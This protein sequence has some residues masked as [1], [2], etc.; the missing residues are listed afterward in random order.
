MQ[1]VIDN[2]F[3]EIGPRTPIKKEC[4]N[5]TL[6]LFQKKF[7]FWKQCNTGGLYTRVCLHEFQKWQANWKTYKLYHLPVFFVNTLKEEILILIFFSNKSGFPRQGITSSHG[8]SSR[9]TSSL[10]SRRDSRRIDSRWR[11][12]WRN[13]VPDSR[14]RI[15]LIW[16]HGNGGMII[17]F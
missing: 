1:I 11:R 2:K 3:Y 16:C 10:G 6:I 8:T 4:S 7:S 5:I 13:S 15:L 14:D 17:T 9:V 12:R